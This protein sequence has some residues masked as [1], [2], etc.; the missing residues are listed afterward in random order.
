MSSAAS[1]PKAR[2]K[3]KINTD[4]IIEAIEGILK[5]TFDC[6]M[7]M[8]EQWENKSLGMYRDAAEKL[9]ATYNK[10]KELEKT[11]SINIS[12]IPNIRKDEIGSADIAIL[13]SWC[14]EI[15]SAV[16]LLKKPLA[17]RSE[18]K[19]P[20]KPLQAEAAPQQE[21]KEKKPEDVILDVLRQLVSN[22]KQ[23]PHL[24]AVKLE[25]DKSGSDL[26]TKLKVIK[27]ILSPEKK[28]KKE[29]SGFS[30]FKK[31]NPD[32]FAKINEI[33][34]PGQGIE[35]DARHVRKLTSPRDSLFLIFAII[36]KPEQ[37]VAGIKKDLIN[38][39]REIIDEKKAPNRKTKQFIT[40]I[41]PK[42]EELE[43]KDLPT[44][45]PD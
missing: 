35:L 6:T 40:E 5:N 17:A 26:K 38:C 10:L 16:T 22:Y 11:H 12:P 42:L 13:Q 18:E 8:R 4:E 37:D 14:A 9:I 15:D 19:A 44:A 39:L 29:K 3:E 34:K 41:I 30:L 27:N 33:I 25:L 36:T 45:R 1:S 20:L 21:V 24:Q 7:D 31:S 23:T 32:K 2:E 28:E 43:I